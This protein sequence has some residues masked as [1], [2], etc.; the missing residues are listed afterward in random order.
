MKKQEQQKQTNKQE[1][2]F[3]SLAVIFLVEAAIAHSI[4]GRDTGGAGGAI[5]PPHSLIREGTAPP[6]LHYKEQRPYFIL[7]E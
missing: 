4:I 6:L 5:A 7:G 2:Q 3:R 1:V